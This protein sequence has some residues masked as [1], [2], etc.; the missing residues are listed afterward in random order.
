M[1][2]TKWESTH[3]GLK[4]LAAHIESLW[5]NEILRSVLIWPGAALAIWCSFYL[6][7]IWL[8]SERQRR[9]NPL[10]FPLVYFLLLPCF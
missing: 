9:K 7:D 4:F 10:A 1:I 8:V 5:H 2:E 3:Y 6:K